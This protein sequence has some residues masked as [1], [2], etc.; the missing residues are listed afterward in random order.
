MLAEETLLHRWPNRALTCHGEES[1]PSLHSASRPTQSLESVWAAGTANPGTSSQLHSCVPW[2]RR[3][4]DLQTNPPKLQAGLLAMSHTP[5]QPLPT[6]LVVG[7]CQPEVL[8]QLKEKK[9]IKK[10]CKVAALPSTCHETIL[11][12]LHCASA[13]RNC[14]L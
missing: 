7:S 13:I 8:L 1:A 9:K 3:G 10:T 2:R 12:V 14:R 11:N 4:E 6:F 5:H